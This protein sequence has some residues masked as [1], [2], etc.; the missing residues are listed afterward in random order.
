MF[1]GDRFSRQCDEVKAPYVPLRSNAWCGDDS[2]LLSTPVWMQR[3][4]VK[5]SQTAGIERRLRTSRKRASLR[6]HRDVYPPVIEVVGLPVL[7][8][9]HRHDV[10]ILLSALQTGVTIAGR[11][12]GQ[13]GDGLPDAV[14]GSEASQPVAALEAGI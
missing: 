12:G 8:V 13:A 1:R 11:V 2:P 6:R 7:G 4:L 5:A 3:E 14:G 10:P 9:R